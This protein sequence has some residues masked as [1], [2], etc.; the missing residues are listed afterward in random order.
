MTSGRADRIRIRSAQSW[1][2]VILAT[3]GLGVRRV[4]HLADGSKGDDVVA[5][6]MV[7]AA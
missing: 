4:M 1:H 7:R 5:R 2:P 6:N 3:R